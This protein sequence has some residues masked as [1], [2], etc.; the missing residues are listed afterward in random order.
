MALAD[1]NS[2]DLFDKTGSGKKRM[3]DDKQAQVSQ[4]FA[5]GIINEF[6][7]TPDSVEALIYQVKLLQEDVDELRRYVTN[8][9][10]GSAIDFGSGLALAAGI[11]LPTSPAGSGRLYTDK[12]GTVKVG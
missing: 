1:K 4:S 11:S 2:E 10:T 6:P 9:A 8:E 5:S 7:G 3:T 12:T